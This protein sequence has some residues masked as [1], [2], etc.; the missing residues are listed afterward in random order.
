MREE[1]IEALR[2]ERLATTGARRASHGGVLA[3]IRQAAIRL[4]A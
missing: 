1:E 4:V 2:R 3:L